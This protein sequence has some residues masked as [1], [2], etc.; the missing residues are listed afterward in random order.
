MRPINLELQNFMSY[1]PDPQALNFNGLH[2]ACLTGENGHGKSALIDAITWALWG[3]ARARRDDELIHLGQE[4]MR[5]AL[6][7]MLGD[8]QYRI[9]RQRDS[10]GRGG[11]ALEFQIRSNGQYRPLTG[12]SIKE[13]QERIVD[14]IHMDH[15]TFINSALLL[16]GR[17]DEFTN[18][19]PGERKRILAEILGLGLYDELEE[20]AK[21]KGRQ[22]ET[23]LAGIQ[24]KAQ[25][26][27]EGLERLPE[28]EAELEQAALDA[29][30]LSQESK[31]AQEEVRRL[32]EKQTEGS[33]KRQ[34]LDD[35]EAEGRKRVK[36]LETIRRRMIA[37]H[38]EKLE[39]C[40]AQLREVEERIAGLSDRDEQRERNETILRDLESTVAGLKA[41]NKALKVEMEA[42][43]EEMNILAGAEAECP[44]CG[45]ELTLQ[46]RAEILSEKESEGTAQAAKYRQNEIEIT[47]ARND[48]AGALE[49]RSLI[50]RELQEMKKLQQRE[51]DLSKALVELSTEADRV[52]EWQ[53]QEE[54]LVGAIVELSAKRDTLRKDL[55]DLP[56]VERNLATW[57]V[58]TNQLGN[59]VSVANLRVGAATQKIEH[60]QYLQAE[61][62]KLEQK[63][64]EAV[65]RKAVYDELRQAFGRRGI[66]AMII[67]T[68][69]PEIEEEA[70]RLL[71]AMTEGRMH[72][73]FNSQRETKKGTLMETLDIKVGDE[74]GSR[75]YDLF[76]GGEAFRINFAIRIAISKLLARRA[77]AQLETLIMDEGFGSQDTQGRDRLVEAINSVKGDFPLIVVITHIDEL[78]E[79]FANR[80]EIV[81]G[82]A[83][84]IISVN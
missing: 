11:S 45:T 63:H 62:E 14:T 23:S 52:T 57:K 2:L 44:L 4:Q 39:G 65:G 81:K 37:F 15:D 76:S 9:I 79:A 56:Q 25:Q 53:E 46:H 54:K 33:L 36:E 38:P 83:G 28:Y 1:G 5:V 59:E 71:G 40:Q 19:T 8:R 73:S 30:R 10:S 80:I 69:L 70:N 67:E 29:E 84:S 49:E 43:R 41:T 72:V 77:G 27:K 35:I 66:Q 42:L 48:K 61:K 51:L 18:Q 31:E 21:E 20:R 47:E 24:A 74:L 26:M 12:D 32:Q 82:P 7:F 60:C 6:D 58:R 16:Q 75:N 64:E 68:V 13:T 78:K 22:A 55:G 17:A 3:K 34:A 50:A